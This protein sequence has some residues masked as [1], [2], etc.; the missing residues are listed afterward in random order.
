MSVLSKTE[1]EIPIWNEV[2]KRPTFIRRGQSVFNATEKYYGGIAREVQFV[3]GIDCFYDDSQIQ[4]FL[5]CAYLRY[6]A[7]I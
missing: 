6:L 1:F 2:N 7:H 3:D 4:P 5:D